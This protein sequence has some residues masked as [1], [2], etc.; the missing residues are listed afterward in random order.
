MKKN[1]LYTWLK[2]HVWQTNQS[3]NSAHVD[4]VA[5]NHKKSL[6]RENTIN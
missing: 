2:A 1:N 6:K 5:V 3:I 4:R